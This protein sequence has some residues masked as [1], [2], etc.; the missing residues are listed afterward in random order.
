[1]HGFYWFFGEIL[2]SRHSKAWTNFFLTILTF[3]IMVAIWIYVKKW[4]KFIT[5]FLKKQENIFFGYNFGSG[6]ASNIEEYYLKIS[7]YYHAQIL[8]YKCLNDDKFRKKQLARKHIII[9]THLKISWDVWFPTLLF[10]LPVYIFLSYSSF[11][12]PDIFIYFLRLFVHIY[13]FTDVF[14]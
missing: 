4:V 3:F 9:F 12:F 1:M 14:V 7:S 11:L 2:P 10:V 6:L 8:R 5:C 13:I